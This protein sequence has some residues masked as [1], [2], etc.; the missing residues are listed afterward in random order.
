[1]RPSPFSLSL[2]T[3]YGQS[4][5][6]LK[7]TM[8]KAVGPGVIRLFVGRL[9]CSAPVY[10]TS[11]QALSAVLLF[12]MIQTNA[13]LKTPEERQVHRILEKK[14]GLQS[15]AVNALRRFASCDVRTTMRILMSSNHDANRASL[16][17][18]RS[19]QARGA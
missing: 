6:R 3:Y 14:M 8:T 1:M 12:S 4:S 10:L 2:H 18:R 15:D 9:E 16:D 19:G 7:I 13:L 11:L 5:L 17:W